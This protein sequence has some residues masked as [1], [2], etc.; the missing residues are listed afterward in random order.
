MNRLWNRAGPLLCL[1][2]LGLAIHFLPGCRR[3]G[4]AKTENV[5]PSILTVVERFESYVL[6][7]GAIPEAERDVRKADIASVRETLA[8]A[9]E[10]LH[11]AEVAGP[12]NAILPLHDAYVNAD[13]RLSALQKRIYLRSTAIVRVLLEKTVKTNEGT[14]PPPENSPQA[15]APRALTNDENGEIA[16]GPKPD[17]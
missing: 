5:S 8:T 13:P 4:E 16:Y 11:M 15:A 2:L 17:H 14:K 9:G 6:Q 12:L 7:D 10:K 1:L 3:P